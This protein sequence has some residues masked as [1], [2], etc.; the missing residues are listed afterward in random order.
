[1]D[2]QRIV[3]GLLVIVDLYLYLVRN[4]VG[5]LIETI[6]LNAH[7]HQR[8]RFLVS[9]E[10]AVEVPGARLGQTDQMF[11]TSRYRHISARRSTIPKN[12]RNRSMPRPV[13]LDTAKTFSKC[14]QLDWRVFSK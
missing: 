14:V 10:A 6:C 12:T 4:L 3:G 13:T 11:L 9:D 2:M 8:L 5:Q 1:M 7:A